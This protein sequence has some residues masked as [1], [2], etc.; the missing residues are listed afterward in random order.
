MEKMVKTLA[1]AVFG[2]ILALAGLLIFKTM[3]I[4]TPY[5][6]IW[7]GMVSRMPSPVRA[8]ACQK[9]E[10]R[11]LTTPATKASFKKPPAGCEA[12]WN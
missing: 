10:Q 7:S 9:V 5:D 3:T 2:L 4:T 8:W 11:L 12:L 1:G 6:D